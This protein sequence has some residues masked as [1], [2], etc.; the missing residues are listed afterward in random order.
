VADKVKKNL[1][2]SSRNDE[3][4]AEKQ[5]STDPRRWRSRTEQRLRKLQ[6]LEKNGGPSATPSLADHVETSLQLVLN[7]K[8][9]ADLTLHQSLVL[10]PQAPMPWCRDEPDENNRVPLIR[11]LSTPRGIS[12]QVLLLAL[13]LE[14]AKSQGRRGAPTPVPVSPTRRDPHR[15]IAWT[16]LVAVYTEDTTAKYGSTHTAG[17]EAKR[18]RQVKTAL[19]ALDSVGMVAIADP[20]ARKRYEN[21]RVL[22]EGVDNHNRRVRYRLPNPEESF[23]V[24]A[25]LV[26]NGW[27]GVLTPSELTLF[28][29]LAY[30]DSR[31]TPTSPP[32]DLPP[33][34]RE[35]LFAFGKETFEAHK[36]L[37]LFGLI[38]T[39]RDG[40]RE[41]DYTRD[42]HQGGPGDPHTFDLI[43]SGLDE[44]AIPVMID[45]LELML[46]STV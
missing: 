19:E 5:S 39:T 43:A 26:V 30:L 2:E 10:R 36:T 28:L 29:V 16:D 17:H 4:I 22:A 11:H 15:Q 23:T 31:Q 37:R 35:G 44:P 21:F 41:Y 40:R 24:P 6:F 3:P 38:N 45:A 12:L 9:P 25:A 32:I 7:G 34:K 13:L 14:Q 1:S 8:A 46:Q 20:K 27:A 42:F 18:L 33:A